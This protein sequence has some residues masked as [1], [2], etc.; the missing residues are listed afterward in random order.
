VPR[1]DAQII[2]LTNHSPYSVYGKYR[3]N[4]PKRMDPVDMVAIEERFNI[5]RLD[6]DNLAEKRKYVCMEALSEYEYLETLYGHLYDNFETLINGGFLKKVHVRDALKTC[7]QLYL[8]RNASSGQVLSTDT[9]ILFL[10]TVVDES[11]WPVFQ[12]V[13]RQYART[14][15]Y[16]YNAVDVDETIVTL[17][18]R[19]RPNT[20]GAPLEVATT[21]R[22]PRAATITRVPTSRPPPV[23]STHC[24]PEEE[25]R[26]ESYYGETDEDEMAALVEEDF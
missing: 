22:V 19:R 16:G 24:I 12:E 13:H 8:D 5:I 26:M 1:K 18:G 7:Y 10:R 6:G 11:D 25:N 17:S 2:V 15:F 3:K 21:S 23:P 14:N 20:Q 4:G 9:F